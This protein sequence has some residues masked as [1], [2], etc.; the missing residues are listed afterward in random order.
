MIKKLVLVFIT[1]FAVSSYAQEGT[2]S[3]YSFYGIGSL[4]FKG[5]VENRSMGGLSIYSDSIHVNL[6]NPAS[7]AT[8]N[9]QSFGGESRPVKFAVGGSH[10]SL[11]LKTSSESDR[12]NA[13]SF[14]YIALSVPI[15]KRFGAG[16]G[17]MPYTSVGY[18][19]ETLNEDDE[20]FPTT[21]LRLS[22]S[23]SLVVP[24]CCV[25][26]CLCANRA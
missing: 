16:L 13:S 6:R 20:F 11:N 22:F 14:D 26:C 9:L 4:K 17:L 12:A 7:Y 8:P 10:S 21:I 15:S 2:A 1:V 23:A 25:G 18:K 3:P 24:A 5:T 19:L